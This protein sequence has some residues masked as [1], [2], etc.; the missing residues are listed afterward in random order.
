MP[1]IRKYVRKSDGGDAGAQGKTCNIKGC[2]APA[3][4][5]LSKD[6]FEEYLRDA[7]LELKSDKER[8]ITPCDAHYKALKK[9]KKKDDKIAKVKQGMGAISKVGSR[10][11]GSQKG[12]LE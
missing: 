9:K 11:T 3:V 10:G 4:R 1:Q 2:N 12:Y 6:L 5:S 7:G 8:K